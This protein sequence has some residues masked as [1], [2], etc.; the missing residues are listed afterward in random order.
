MCNSMTRDKHA[1][2][3]LNKLVN[4]AGHIT[5]KFS[6]RPGKMVHKQAGNSKAGDKLHIIST[7]AIIALLL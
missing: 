6:D 3:Y 4:I 1:R 7:W 2:K 5:G